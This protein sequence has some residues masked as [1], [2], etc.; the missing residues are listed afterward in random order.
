MRNKYNNETIY[1]I[2]IDKSESQVA[3]TFKHTYEQIK[4]VNTIQE[5]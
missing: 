4:E 1:I 2:T 3:T 5:G